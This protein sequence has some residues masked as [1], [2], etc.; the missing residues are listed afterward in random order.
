MDNYLD[1]E[2][3]KKLFNLI[4]RF[5]NRALG[6]KPDWTK[7]IYDVNFSSG[8]LTRSRNSSSTSQ[9]S[10]TIV[11][12]HELL[13]QG[14]MRCNSNFSGSNY[15]NGTYKA[16]STLYNKQ[17]CFQYSVNELVPVAGSSSTSTSKTLTTLD[18]DPFG[19]ILYYEYGTAVTANQLIYAN[20]LY[21]YY[22]V[23]LR[24]TFNIIS[25]DSNKDVFVKCVPQ[26][27]GRVKLATTDPLTQTLPTTEDGFVYILLG[28]SINRASEVL[29]TFNHPVYYFKDGALRLWTNNSCEPYVVNST[30]GVCEKSA[31]ELMTLYSSGIT[32]MQLN[33]NGRKYPLLTFFDSNSCGWGLVDN[34][35]AS[36]NFGNP[37]AYQIFQSG[38]T[39]T[40]TT[41]T[42][43]N[44][45]LSGSYSDLSNKPDLT[46]YAK[47]SDHVPTG[48]AG[49]SINIS[50]D[51]YT[52]GTGI[53]ISGTQISMNS[54]TGT[55]SQFSQ[56]QN[57]SSYDLIY[58]VEE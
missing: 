45:S 35:A 28:H 15:T 44:V 40:L 38:T 46:I 7:T 26:S 17:I 32:N 49:G 30:N 43:A 21:E 48:S 56:L 11:G 1:K 53:K 5:V 52:A 36:G 8:K 6:R 9:T 23:D 33:Y 18:F 58:I 39:L 12:S 57:P 55:E 29:L 25:L 16:K 13:T 2:G 31:S 22:H 41:K 37:A 14:S 19:V 51:S 50:G 54:W 3:A 4:V 34:T 42:F 24:Y 10:S 47:T 20:R 27:N